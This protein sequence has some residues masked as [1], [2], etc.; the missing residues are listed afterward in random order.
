MDTYGLLKVLH[1][2]LALVSGLG[3]ALRGFIR[4]VLDRPLAHPLVRFGP[5]LVDTLLLASGIALWVLLGLSPI[6][7]G[8][9]GVKLVLIVVYIV[10]G[11]GAFRMRSAG[12]AVLTY[13]AALAV[14]LA[15]AWLALYRPL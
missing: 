13:L 11:I 3:F 2:S 10:L 14:F 15:V 8:W 1:I 7:A 6:A 4:V 12:P 9:F 5:H